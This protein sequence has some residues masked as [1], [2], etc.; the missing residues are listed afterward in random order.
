MWR[1]WSRRQQSSL[2]RKQWQQQ[3]QQQQQRT[4]VQKLRVLLAGQLVLLVAL[5]V[6]GRWFICD[7]LS[8]PCCLSAP[9]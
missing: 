9:A 6:R 4:Q 7:T 3:Q 5:L 1:R 2:S 8:L